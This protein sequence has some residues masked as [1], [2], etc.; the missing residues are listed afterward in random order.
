MHNYLRYPCQ[1]S[2]EFTERFL[3]HKHS[4][5]SGLQT[6]EAPKG[7]AYADSLDWRTKG[8]VTSVQSQVLRIT[9]HSIN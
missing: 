8:A 6:F 1:T 3:T 4:Q 9:I 5:R 7:V 2:A